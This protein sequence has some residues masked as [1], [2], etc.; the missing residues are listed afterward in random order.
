MRCTVLPASNLDPDYHQVHRRARSGK[1]RS[2]T[3]SLLPCFVVIGHGR[4]KGMNINLTRA[5]GIVMDGW[6]ILVAVAA[7]LLAFGIFAMTTGL[8]ITVA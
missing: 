8:G 3:F 1:S 4:K 6:P 2:A 5:H 7:Y